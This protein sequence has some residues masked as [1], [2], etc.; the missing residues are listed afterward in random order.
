MDDQYFVFATA[1]I[2]L[3]YFLVNVVVRKFDPF[4]PV[5]LFLV[6]YVQVYIIQ[7]VSY[8]EWALRVRGQE[9]VAAANFRALWALVWFLTVYHLGIS[10]RLAPVLPRPPRGWSKALIAGGSPFL[11]LWGL[12]CAGVVI[13]GELQGTDSISPEEALLRSFPFVMMVAAILLIVTGRSL[14]SPQPLFFP[15]GLLV[16][17]AYVAIW[18]FNGKRSHSLIGVLSTVCACYITRLKRP[19]WPVLLATSFA[20]VLVVAIAI[21]WRN[22]DSYEFSASGFTQYLSDFKLKKILESLNINDAESEQETTTYETTEYGGFLLMMDTVPHKSDYD[23]GANYIRVCSTFIP[24]IVWPTKP[25]FGREQW[26]SAYIAGSEMDRGEDFTSPAIGILGA[27][28]LNGGAVGT[29]IVLACIALL[30]R[31][32]YEYFRLYSEVPWVQFWWAITFYNAWFMVV[33]DDPMVWFYYNW[34]FSTFPIVVLLWWAL[35]MV[36]R[37]PEQPLTRAAVVGIQQ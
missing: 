1:G 12:Y 22:N 4:A 6:G 32:A 7:A 21:G 23:Y 13:R 29:L 3:V 11:I 14:A 19:S 34:G 15:A 27:T 31:A 5:W 37:A 30:L 28:Q 25:L 20:G 17:A 18:M 33:N 16:A 26:I 8:R 10:P 35:K 24:R 36:A 9:L 2:I